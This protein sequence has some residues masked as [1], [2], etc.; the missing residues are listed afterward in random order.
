MTYRE[1]VVVFPCEGEELLGIVASPADD[2]AASRVGV[3]IVVGGPQYRAGS[4]RQFVLLA[5]ALAERGYHCLRFDYRGMGDSSGDVRDFQQIGADIHA[6]IET[7]RDSRPEVR[8][9]AL[10]GLCDGASAS[11]LYVA[12]FGTLARADSLCLLNPWVRSAD[13]LARVTVKH[14]YLRRLTEKQF[15]LKLLRGGSG[16]RAL[17]ELAANLSAARKGG[18][19]SD[20]G[21]PGY[22]GHMAAAWWSFPGP[23]LLLL[24][25]ED[26][27]A[28]EFLDHVRS[29]P[30]LASL[31]T[32]ANLERRDLP[33]VDH[34][35][36]TAPWRARVEQVTAD[37][38][39]DVAAPG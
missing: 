7:L 13:S 22:Q 18:F 26:Y 8:R 34:T 2:G 28:R 27:V 36:S 16:L 15:W 19:D 10:W 30:A 33:G 32:R 21:R 6:A 1:Q 35:F 17:R 31:L 29:T 24:S 11:L 20:G 5:R 14:Y 12:A 9:I 39:D 23:M 3:V 38:L 4:H 25:G 37:W